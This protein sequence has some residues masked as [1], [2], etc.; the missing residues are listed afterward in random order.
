MYTLL[1][2]SN[3][4]ADT[5]ARSMT[6][7]R[8]ISSYTLRS[9]PSSPEWSFLSWSSLKMLQCWPRPI[10]M[11]QR[12]CHVAFSHLVTHRTGFSFHKCTL[13]HHWGLHSSGGWSMSMLQNQ[14]W[15]SFWLEIE[16]HLAILLTQEKRQNS[17]E[18]KFAWLHVSDVVLVCMSSSELYSSP[19]SAE[20]KL[21]DVTT[22]VMQQLKESPIAFL[23]IVA[24]SI[25]SRS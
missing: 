8:E 16:C 3:L 15:R 21:A 17:H 6:P 14:W 25:N 20:W 12:E 11:T 9:V 22:P 2:M 19:S 10:L 24:L 23:L 13:V 5:D 7:S 4:Y 18:P 1:N